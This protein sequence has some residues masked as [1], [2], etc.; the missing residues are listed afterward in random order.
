MRCAVAV[1]VAVAVRAG[2]ACNDVC[3]TLPHTKKRWH[4]VLRNQYN[5]H[6]VRRVELKASAETIEL[7]FRPQAKDIDVQHPVLPQTGRQRKEERNRERERE[8]H[9][10]KWREGGSHISQLRGT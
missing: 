6:P 5:C 1:A 7:H 10:E 9:R 8:V 2:A 3:K 4:T